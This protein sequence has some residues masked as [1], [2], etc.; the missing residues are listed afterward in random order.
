[1][2]YEQLKE[3]TISAFIA[4]KSDQCTIIAMESMK[5]RFYDYI[6]EV[7]IVIPIE[8]Y[9][10]IDKSVRS[11][12]DWHMTFSGDNIPTFEWLMILFSHLINE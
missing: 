1:M 9:H 11:N 5:I 7:V 2:K 8:I 4:E 12:Y 3:Q 6:K 10:K